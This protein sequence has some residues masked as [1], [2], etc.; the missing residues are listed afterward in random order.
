VIPTTDYFSLIES[1]PGLGKVLKGTT[2]KAG[3]NAAQKAT[4]PKKKR[5]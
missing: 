1:Y 3:G 2:S 4:A 5:K